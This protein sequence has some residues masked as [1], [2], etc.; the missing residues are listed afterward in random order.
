MNVPIEFEA[1]FD[2][3]QLMFRINV[4]KCVIYFVL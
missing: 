2:K 4:I 1:L 3:M